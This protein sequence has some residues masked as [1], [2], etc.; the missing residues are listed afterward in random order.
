MDFTEALALFVRVYSHERNDNGSTMH[1]REILGGLI[2]VIAAAIEMCEP[3]LRP[4][5]LESVHKALDD[6][7]AMPQTKVL[8]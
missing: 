3:E 4:K 1:I 8:N 7:M 6:R 5:L 2:S